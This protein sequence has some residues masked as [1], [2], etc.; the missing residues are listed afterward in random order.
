MNLLR[1]TYKKCLS[2]LRREIDRYVKKNIITESH[3]ASAMLNNQSIVNNYPR[4]QKI[5]VSL[6]TFGKRIDS[7]YI[8]I[9]SIARQ[10]LKPDI[11][12]L[13]LAENEFNKK[14]IPITLRK[15]QER[16]LTISFYR[17]IG[18]YKKLIPT[19]KKYPDEIIITIDDDMIY[20][21][22][23]IEKLIKNHEKYP[24][25]IC[26]NQARIITLGKNNNPKPYS[27]WTRTLQCESPAYEYI[28][29]GV[30]GVLYFP[31]C[32]DSSVTDEALFRKLS[33][34]NDDLWF[35]ILSLIKGVKTMVINE[36]DPSDYIPLDSSNHEA[37]ANQNVGERMNN[38]QF[39]ALLNHFNLNLSKVFAQ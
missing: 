35:K 26:C 24:D 31:G 11:V 34:T 7:V 15:F 39:E 37:L 6:T 21:N 22:T 23:L 30:G 28:P 19:L 33:P 5:V 9:E 16:G 14:T 27:K 17:P 36:L 25:C 20:P 1:K 10:T 8:T 29:I 4:N 32:F 18:P 38:P 2:V 13:W 12:I 3:R